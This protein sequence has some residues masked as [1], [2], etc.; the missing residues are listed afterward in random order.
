MTT[1]TTTTLPL[2]APQLGWMLP[3]WRVDDYRHTTTLARL[4]EQLARAHY[5]GRLPPQQE[6]F[7]WHLCAVSAW[8]PAATPVASA[9][10]AGASA[11]WR[12]GGETLARFVQ[13]TRPTHLV[14]AQRDTIFLEDGSAWQGTSATLT[15]AQRARLQTRGA[16]HYVAPPTGAVST[17]RAAATRPAGVGRTSCASCLARGCASLS[18]RLLTRVAT[19]GGLSFL[20]WQMLYPQ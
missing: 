4:L 1:T 18:W 2:L 13:R 15:A 7:R 10:T 3:A 11:A 9:D 6:L 12:D 8:P 14:L 17:T 5:C 16:L 19:L 20:T